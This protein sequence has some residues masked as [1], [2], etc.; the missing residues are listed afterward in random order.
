MTKLVQSRFWAL[1]WAL[2]LVG[3]RR[4]NMTICSTFG[5]CIAHSGPR[6]RSL[7]TSAGAMV[8]DIARRICVGDVAVPLRPVHMDVFQ[9]GHEDLFALELTSRQGDFSFLE[10]ALQLSAR[11]FRTHAWP[12]LREV[13]KEVL[14]NRPSVANS[15]K[16]SRMPNTILCIEARGHEVL[17]QNSIRA[18]ILFFRP[19]SEIEEIQW[20]LEELEKDLDQMGTILRKR[21]RQ[22]SS[23]ALAQ[24]N[25]GSAGPEDKGQDEGLHKRSRSESPEGLEGGAG[26]MESFGTA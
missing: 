22:S 20:L 1:V 23:D 5:S 26:L 14:Q 18:T 13:R 25:P 15:K 2:V 10:K 9:E 24:D 19:G 12:L 16:G 3:R 6:E 8:F 17:A 4:W 11:T 21:K 7:W